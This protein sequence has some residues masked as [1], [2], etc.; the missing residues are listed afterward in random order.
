[1]TRNVDISQQQK[2][3]LP[4]GEGAGAA[5]GE[6]LTGLMVD[7]AAVPSAA[8]SLSCPAIGCGSEGA[9]RGH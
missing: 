1:M 5:A 4:G 6:E 8:T 2:S 9:I 7:W 3:S